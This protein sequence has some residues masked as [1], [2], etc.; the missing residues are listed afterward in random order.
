MK[1]LIGKSVGSAAVWLLV[2]GEAHAAGTALDVQ[3]ARG[4]GMAAAMTAMVDDSSAVFY[5]PA[6]IAQGRIVDAQV[7]DSLIMPSFRF[8]PAGG[9]SNTSS[10]E[11]IPPFTAYV[12]GGVTDHFSIGIGVFEPY[13]STVTWPG[14]WVGKSLATSAQFATYDINPT[15]AYQI[16]PLRVGAG[17]QIVRATVDLKQ[18]IETGSTEASSELGADAW[19]VGANVGVQIEAIKRYLSIGAHYRSAVK[20][21]FDG[22]AHF[23][24]VPPELQSTLH[25]QAVKAALVNPDSLALAVASR[26]TPRLVLD[27]EVVWFGWAKFHSITITFPNDASDTLS[28]SEPK[29]WSNEVNYH[30]GGEFTFNPEWR[31]RAGVLFDPS[32]SP[33]NTLAPDIP[34]ADRLNLAVGGSYVHESGFRVDLGY[35]FL[36]L[37]SRTS[38]APQLPGRYS[39]LVDI[40]GLSVGYRTPEPRRAPEPMPAFTPAESDLAPLPPAPVEAPP[41]PVPPAPAGPPPAPPVSTWP[42]DAH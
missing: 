3:S 16:G 11:V 14:G 22:N 21:D 31:V 15:A 28:R 9:S 36:V 23:G 18:A 35:Q 24:N 19:G 4:T 7:G 8:R 5:N 32:P 17:L 10:F 33:A 6:G 2:A 42:M 29:N 37:F 34:D 27:A 41:A 38:T 40:L 1:N 30:V 25:D 39:G 26:P 20:L 13:G 12:S